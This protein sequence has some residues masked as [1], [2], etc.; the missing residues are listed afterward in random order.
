MPFFSFSFFIHDVC[1]DV[2][3]GH[4][5][6]MLSDSS[7]IMIKFSS[8]LLVVMLTT[9]VVIG[10]MT[11]ETDVPSPM[12]TNTRRYND[13][14]EKLARQTR[15]RPRPAITERHSST[16]R[17]PGSSQ[18]SHGACRRFSFEGRTSTAM[19]P[20]SALNTLCSPASIAMPWLL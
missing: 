3:S 19:K 16:S 2:I 1:N 6:S 4:C 15:S 17:I 13:I 18:A 10:Q 11:A 5:L 20:Q 8:S 12:R 14:L 9:L 7:T